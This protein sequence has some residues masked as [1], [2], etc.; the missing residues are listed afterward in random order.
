[1]LAGL[2]LEAKKTLE[3]PAGCGVDRVCPAGGIAFY[4]DVFD[5]R[6]IAVGVEDA[7]VEVVRDLNKAL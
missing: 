3:A 2:H 1:M 6:V 7:A 5:I 4:K